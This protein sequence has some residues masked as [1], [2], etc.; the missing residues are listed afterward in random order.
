MAYED[1]KAEEQRQ[2][3]A[4]AN[5]MKLAMDESAKGFE[6]P[7]LNACAGALVGLQIELLASIGDGRARKAMQTTME[8]ELKRGLIE[9]VRNPNRAISQVMV[10]GGK[11]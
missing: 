10:L 7:M 8:R 5:A 2:A 6:T 4:L 3:T 9:A 11:H 1:Y